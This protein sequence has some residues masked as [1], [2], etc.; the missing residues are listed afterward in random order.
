M[1]LFLKLLSRDQSLLVVPTSNKFCGSFEAHDSSLST[2]P[3]VFYDEFVEV[4]WNIGLDFDSE[5]NSLSCV[6]NLLRRGAR[7]A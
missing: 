5:I 1:V 7:K 6:C 3:P 4:V 2:D